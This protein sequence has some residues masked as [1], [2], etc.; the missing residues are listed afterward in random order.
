MGEGYVS[1]FKELMEETDWDLY[2]TGK[3]EKCNDCMAHCGYEATAVSDTFANPM[4]A[5]KVSVSGVNTEGPLVDDI[6][7]HNARPAKYTFD[8]QVD[9]ALGDIQEEKS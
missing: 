1:T 9:S 2:G 4:K 6:D 5:L 7:L 3:Y 8:K